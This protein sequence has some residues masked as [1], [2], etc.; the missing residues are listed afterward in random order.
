VWRIPAGDLRAG[1]GSNFPPNA[2]PKKSNFVEY[3]VAL[4]IKGLSPV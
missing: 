2:S 4:G 3:F 1:L